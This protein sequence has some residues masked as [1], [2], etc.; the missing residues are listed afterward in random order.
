[1]Y[2]REIIGVSVGEHKTAD[3]VLEAMK[4]IPYS[5]KDTE[6]FHTDRGSEFVNSKLDQLLETNGIERS[7]SAP[8]TPYDN[9]VSER[10]Y[11]S[12]KTELVKQMEF[13]TI[14][15]LRVF[16]LDYVHWWNHVR[17]HSSLNNLTPVEFKK[18]NQ[19]MFS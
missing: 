3:L 16:T 12:Y 8:G 9:A 4:S 19:S 15:S 7:L 14:D 5:L 6:L 11:R 17:I 10:T 13:Q 1:M 18:A 2:N